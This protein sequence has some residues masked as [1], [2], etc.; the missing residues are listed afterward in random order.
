MKYEDFIWMCQTNE[1]F[2]SM[3]LL[4]T[5]LFCCSMIMKQILRA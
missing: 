3:L 4:G 1:H 5:S 2:L